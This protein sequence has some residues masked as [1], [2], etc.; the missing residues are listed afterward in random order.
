MTLDNIHVGTSGW[1]YKDWKGKFYDEET[2]QDDQLSVYAEVFDTVELNKSFYN[3]PDKTS[4]KSWLKKTPND[5]LFSCKASRYITHMKKLEDPEEGVENLLRS[6][7]VFDNKLGPILFQCPPNWN[8]NTK[9]L[10]NLL[11]ALPDNHRYVFEFRDESW[12]TDEIYRM[13]KDHNAA[14]CL[15]D[16]EGFQ[17]PELITADFVYIRLHGPEENAYQGSYD[18]R[19]LA[20]WVQ[21]MLRWR[22]EGNR[23]FCYFD[24]DQKS[25]APLDAQ[26]LIESLKKQS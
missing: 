25:K 15:Y 4:I 12:F 13:L 19:T 1:N 22:D 8:V 21:K 2:K 10:K 18:G 3:L 9:R 26:Q 11:D 6:L 24:N 7:E 5:F 14:L 17:S 23:V 20:G 16:L